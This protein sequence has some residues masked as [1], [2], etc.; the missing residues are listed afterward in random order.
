MLFLFLGIERSTD[1]FVPPPVAP[2]A[3][4]ASLIIFRTWEH[5]DWEESESWL[6]T[7]IFHY[8]KAA[9]DVDGYHACTFRCPQ[10]NYVNEKFIQENS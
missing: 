4:V 8:P 9:W 5:E 6:P 2:V 10:A 7:P 3:P 1:P